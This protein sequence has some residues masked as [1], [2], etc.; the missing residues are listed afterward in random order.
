[1]RHVLVVANETVAGEVLIKS[2]R[3]HAE[4]GPMRVTVVCPITQPRHGTVVYEDTRRAS[5]GRRLD[6][7]LA[8]L[9]DAEI[10]A[11][12]LV[13]DAD[14]VSA[15]RDALAQDGVEEIV[16][17]THPEEKSGWLRGHVVDR[18]RKA[19]GEIPVEHVVVDLEHERDET[20]V[21][22]IANETVIGRPLLDRIRERARRGPSSFLIV[23]PQS[24]PTQSEHPEAERR[25]RRA[26][27][28]LRGEGLEVHGQIAH[29]D[30]VHGR[31]ARRPR[32]A[33][34]RDRG[35]DV[36]RRAVRVVAARFGRAGAEG[37]RRAGRARGDGGFRARGGRGLVEAHAHA[38][39]A[40]G[41]HPPVANVSSRVDAR[42]LGMLL[43]I[44][45]EIMLFG[46]FFTAYFFIRVSGNAEWP[47]HPF[48]L[49]VFI[50]GVNTTILVTSSF[51]MHWALQA[52]KRGN[53][54]GLQAGLV[55]TFL[56]G[57]TFLLT[58]VTEYAR[59]GFAPHD[60]AF[61]TIFYCLTGLHGA[62][63]FV[64]LTILLFVTIRAFR[65]HFSPAHHHGVEIGGI[66]WHFVDVMWIVVYATIYV[67]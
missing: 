56:M 11:H 48:H 66:Y 61:G 6:R 67:L 26:L 25:L 40:H 43:F 44:A 3:E 46:S 64:G 59:V 34:R 31:D 29:P 50:A 10:S 13:V 17:S 45:S 62:H 18:I 49:P 16:V 24:D 47:L 9:R 53:R 5:A 39:H 35:L 37:R 8:I 12:G 30:P 1:M 60:G 57:L 58:Q 7:T 63:V 32:R 19:A 65:G 28:V 42:V 41:E 15:V 36:C 4:R 51:T 38:T 14:P 2:L 52:I 55:L 27:A 54:A 23:C 33:C 21:L 22:V 20:N